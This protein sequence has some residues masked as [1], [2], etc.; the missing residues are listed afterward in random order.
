VNGI[1]AAVLLAATSI[2]SAPALGQAPPHWKVAVDAPIR[3]INTESVS[4]STLWF[5]SMAPG[6]HVTMGPGGVLYDAR[7]VADGRFDTELEFF[8]FPN[9][10]NEEIGVF[11]GGKDLDGAAKSY[12]AFVVRRDGSA[13]VLK[14]SGRSETAV[15]PWTPSPAVVSPEK[16]GKNL[17]RIA[18]DSAGVHFLVNGT[19]LGTWPRADLML[20]GHF[21]MRIGKLVNAHVSRLDML[22]RLA[23]IPRGK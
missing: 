21:G 13:A 16:S 5:T 3:M 1:T 11:L 6:W 10:S 23:P 20:D 22:H 9:A 14:R 2:V 8:I 15:M 7:H 12:V 17:I 4:D 18:M 19:R